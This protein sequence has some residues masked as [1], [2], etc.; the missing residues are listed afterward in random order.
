MS[1]FKNMAQTMNNSQVDELIKFQSTQKL[2]SAQSLISDV[3]SNIC[4][5]CSRESLLEDIGKM[6]KLHDIQNSFFFHDI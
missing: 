6:E 1:D 3:Y 4:R 5:T 2:G